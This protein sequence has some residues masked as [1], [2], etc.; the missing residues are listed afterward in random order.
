MRILI[1]SQE[2]PFDAA[3]VTTGNALRTHQLSTSLSAAGHE[4]SQAWLDRNGGP[5]AF[6]SADELRGLIQ[7]P[8]PGRYPGELLGIA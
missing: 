6:R 2:P 8:R 7:Q 4:L 3:Q 5:G 1:L